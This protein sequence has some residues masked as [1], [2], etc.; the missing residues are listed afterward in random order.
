M[1]IKLF[2]EYLRFSMKRLKADWK[3]YKSSTPLKPS[4]NQ[5]F[6]MPYPDCRKLHFDPKNYGVIAINRSKKDKKE[7]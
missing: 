6:Q 5:S 4:P 2:I 1:K 7:D 3:W